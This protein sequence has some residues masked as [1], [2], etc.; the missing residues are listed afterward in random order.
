MA[1]LVSAVLALFFTSCGG[2]ETLLY[3]G[4]GANNTANNSSS[5]NTVP[6]QELNCNDNIDNDG[7]GFVDCEDQDCLEDGDCLALQEHRCFDHLDNDGDGFIDC[8]DQ[9]CFEAPGC[10]TQ[11]ESCT[12]GLDDD[13]NG[14]IDCEDAFC[15]M[16]PVCTNQSP[17]DPIANTG[18]LAEENCYALTDGGLTIEC[19]ES[20]GDAQPGETCSESTE[21][22]PGLACTGMGGFQHCT[23]VCEQGFSDI[24]QLG[25]FCFA[26]GSQ[27]GLCL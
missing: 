10:T 1:L 21:C 11:Q 20:L 6:E 8:E 27:Y 5:N 19:V 15:A 22:A 18:C 24:C 26:M 23:E 13:G 14:L 25:M 3:S 4:S 9:D 16:T 17:C 7:D 12:N 2:E